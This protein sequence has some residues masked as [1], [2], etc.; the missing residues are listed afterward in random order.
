MLA[1]PKEQCNEELPFNDGVCGNLEPGHGAVEGNF[2]RFGNYSASPFS[3]GIWQF[4]LTP[5][6]ASVGIGA[7]GS[8]IT[9]NT[10]TTHTGCNGG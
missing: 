4:S 3:G 7:A 10:V 8:V 2:G 5:P 1:A 6:L 9:R